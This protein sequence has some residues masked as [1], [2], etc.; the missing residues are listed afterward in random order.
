MI[1]SQ[2]STAGPFN[3]GR[4]IDGV[5]GL[6]ALTGAILCLASK[7]SNHSNP[8]GT[9][10]WSTVGPFT[11][12]LLLIGISAATALNLTS[13][14]VLALS[15]GLGVAAVY[16]HF[17]LPALPTII[18]RAMITPYVLVTGSQFWQLIN[19][20]TGNDLI[21]QLRAVPPTS[22]GAIAPI[23]GFLLAFS[24]VYYAMLIYAPRQ[25]AES[26]GSLVAWVIR[27]MMFILGM[28][29]GATWLISLGS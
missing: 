17:K 12:G 5:L 7:D 18:R 28:A 24:A 9:L 3:L 23:V 11:G 20:V 6:I 25:F 15:A 19:A 1:K 14:A 10:A 13:N 16:A 4:P 29:L 2:T 22:Y 27:Y 26:G 21:G 8:T